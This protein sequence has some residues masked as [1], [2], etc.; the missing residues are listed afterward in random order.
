[1]YKRQGYG[2]ICAEKYGLPHGELSKVDAYDGSH[3]QIDM[4]DLTDDTPLMKQY[5]ANAQTKEELIIE[6]EEKLIELRGGSW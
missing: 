4:L 1:V 5:S 3:A 6:L 2:P